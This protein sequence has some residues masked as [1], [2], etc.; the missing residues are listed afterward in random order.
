[1]NGPW[2]WE[3]KPGSSNLLDADGNILVHMCPYGNR[4]VVCDTEEQVAEIA[5]IIRSAGDFCG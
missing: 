4:R 2:R 3:G 5:E 1:M